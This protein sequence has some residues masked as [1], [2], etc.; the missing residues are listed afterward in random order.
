MH[1]TI[2]HRIGGVH[3]MTVKYSTDEE[4]IWSD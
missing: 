3:K 1:D 2:A 4:I